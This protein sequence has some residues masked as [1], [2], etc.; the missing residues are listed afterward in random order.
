M[1]EI[2]LSSNPL[3]SSIIT[4][5]ELC[6]LLKI[7]K[8]KEMPKNNFIELSMNILGDIGPV[9]CTAEAPGGDQSEKIGFVDH[10]YKLVHEK[11]PENEDNDLELLLNYLK[12]LKNDG[13]VNNLTA[14]TACCVSNLLNCL[15]KKNTSEMML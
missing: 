13:P 12:D 6:F 4:A 10:V 15:L 1:D 7:N 14:N 9:N 5:W 8:D 2:G 3:I 11:N